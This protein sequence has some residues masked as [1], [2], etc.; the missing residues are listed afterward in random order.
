MVHEGVAEEL[1]QD[2]RHGG[3]GEGAA[4]PD[5]PLRL[6]YSSSVRAGAGRGAGWGFGG[7]TAR[8]STRPMETWIVGASARPSSAAPR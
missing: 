6:R 1:P 8:T 3:E 2:G 7:V 4:H 5:P